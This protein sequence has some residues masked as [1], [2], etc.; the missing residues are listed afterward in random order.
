[1][2]CDRSLRLRGSGILVDIRAVF[3]NR[4]GEFGDLGTVRG[5]TKA[6]ITVATLL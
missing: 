4:A 5:A 6:N 2:H 1:L 3:G